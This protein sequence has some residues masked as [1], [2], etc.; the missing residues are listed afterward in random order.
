MAYYDYSHPMLQP[1]AW[2]VTVS[3]LGGLLLVISALLFVFIL[4]R[5]SRKTGAGVEP[6]TFSRLAHGTE[7]TPVALNSFS[8]WIAM[9]IGLTLVN[10]GYPI[11]QLAMLNETSVPV[12]PIGG[13]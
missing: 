1:Q 6:F 5:S 9:M 8:L 11:V 7:H 2:T 10:Y 4:A 13:P 3:A 12:I